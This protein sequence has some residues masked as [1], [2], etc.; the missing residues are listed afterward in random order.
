VSLLEREIGPVPKG[1][2]SAPYPY[3]LTRLLQ[4]LGIVVVV[5]LLTESSGLAGCRP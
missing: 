5:T 3:E 2:S 1:V 4:S